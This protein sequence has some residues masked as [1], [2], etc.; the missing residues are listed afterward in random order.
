MRVFF[1]T[2]AIFAAGQA[3]AANCGSIPN[4]DQR[5]YCRALEQRSPARCVEIRDFN[6]RQQCRAELGDG[7]WNCETISNPGEREMCRARARRAS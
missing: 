7:A 5:A 2:V 6:L 1:L 4:P 3:L